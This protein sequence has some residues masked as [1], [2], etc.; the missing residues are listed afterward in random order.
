MAGH[1][2][3]DEETALVT[4]DRWMKEGGGQLDETDRQILSEVSQN[5]RVH[6]RV[7]NIKEM[8]EVL[9]S[10]EPE[11]Y[12]RFKDHMERQA[13]KHLTFTDLIE[14]ARKADERMREFVVVVAD[15]TLGQAAQVRLWRVDSHMTWRAVARAAYLEGWFYRNWAPASNQLMGMALVEKAAAIFGENFREEPW[16]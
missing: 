13:G 12:R 7:M 3:R 2:L 6:V 1:S 5:G 9:E 8:L 14:L 4:E 16:N 10:T 11:K 15:M